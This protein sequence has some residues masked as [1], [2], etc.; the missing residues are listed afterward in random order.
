MLGK[1]FAASSA[2]LTLFAIV[3]PCLAQQGGHD[4]LSGESGGGQKTNPPA[5]PGTGETRPGAASG[6][7][8]PGV[9]P[10]AP[11]QNPDMTWDGNRLRPNDRRRKFEFY[12]RPRTAF[13]KFDVSPFE[14]RPT[15]GA[16]GAYGGCFLV[17]QGTYFNFYGY[18]WDTRRVEVCN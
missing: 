3:Q 12:P 15:L 4:E 16:F 18:G 13:T 8:T 14:G 2:V 1:S 6:T 11:S 17:P 5:V 9:L 10:P 7:K